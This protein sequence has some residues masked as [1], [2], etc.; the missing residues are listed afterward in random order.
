MPVNIDLESLGLAPLRGPRGGDLQDRTMEHRNSPF[1]ADVEDGVR[2]LH[3][4]EKPTDVAVCGTK[5]EQPWHRLAAYLMVEGKTVPEVAKAAGVAES[6]VYKLKA[7][8][9]F[10]Q[11]LASIAQ[12]MGQTITEKT[13]AEAAASL[14]VLVQLRDNA[15]SE[16]VKLA[17]ATTIYE[18]SQGKPV[19]KVFSVTQRIEDPQTEMQR[20]LSELE[21]VKR[22]QADKTTAEQPNET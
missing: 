17:A 15:E 12:E 13:H 9:W 5:D 16:R 22:A 8:R 20:L 3:R 6:T 11:L 10:Q 7:N 14:A 19:Q 18:H 1:Q 21:S 4:F 2:L